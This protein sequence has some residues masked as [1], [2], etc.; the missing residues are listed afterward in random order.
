MNNNMFNISIDN[1]FIDFDLVK[2][3]IDYMVSKIELLWSIQSLY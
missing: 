2:C 3:S 1:L